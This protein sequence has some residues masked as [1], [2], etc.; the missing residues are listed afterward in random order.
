MS[1]SS[2][3]FLGSCLGMYKLGAFNARNPGRMWEWSCR[4]WKWMQQ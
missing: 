4:L 3:F 2:L 1:L